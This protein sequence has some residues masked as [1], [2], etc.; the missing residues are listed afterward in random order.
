M[1]SALAMLARIRNVLGGRRLTQATAAPAAESRPRRIISLS[2]VKNE[3]DIIEPFIRH[4]A[5]LVD[6][7]VILDNA[8]VD[9]TRRIMIDCARELSNVVVADTETSDFAQS[10]RTTRLLKYCQT[11]FFADFI[12]LLDADEFVASP[13]R[14][15]LLSALEAIPSPGVGLLPWSTFVLTPGDIATAHLDPP[16]SIRQ[17]RA[18]ERPLFRK[19]VLRLD[20]A[21]R[22][23]LVVWDGNHGVI[24]IGGEALPSIDLNELALMHFPVRSFN[25]FAGKAVVGWLACIVR[26]PTSIELNLNFQRRE[27]FGRLMAAG[28]KVSDAELCEASLRY[29]QRLDEID[30]TADVIAADPAIEYVRRHSD[31][32]FVDPLVAIS[33][34]WE[35]SL[36]G[37]RPN[38]TSFDATQR[39]DDVLVDAAPFRFLAETLRPVSVLD[40]GCGAGAYVA[41]FRRLGASRVLGVAD[42]AASATVLDGEI[43]QVHDLTQPLTLGEIY[44]LVIC[45]EVAEHLPPERA[46]E[47]LDSIARHAGRTIVFSAAEPGQP[48]N[49]HINCQPISHW[50]AQWAARGWHPDLVASL[51]VR[52]LATM[53]W[54]RR[55]LIVLRRDKSDSDAIAVL[56]EIGSKPFT[57]YGQPPGIRHFPFTEDLPPPPAGYAPSERGLVAS[58]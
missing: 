27:S 57:W 7:M 4:H 42:T 41:L 17:R 10:E 3:Q 29:A 22:S 14:A 20:G 2:M 13:D 33:R 54:F 55:N 32:R 39:G 9:D 25:Q 36:V 8:S 37:H 1:Q 6:C 11:A 47:L 19:A 56:T 43:C 35:H 44:D 24:S 16:R 5:R 23:D 45:T 28:G 46:A 53:S 38:E 34:S 26:D 40:V 12:L 50:L 18:V 30:W 15:T 51:G 49:G 48:G 21:Y 52:A 31:G 58:P